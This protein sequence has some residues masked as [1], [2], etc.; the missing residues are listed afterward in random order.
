MVEPRKAHLAGRLEHGLGPEHVGSEEQAGVQDGQGVVRLGGEVDD[1]VDLLAPRAFSAARVADVAL[2]EDDP[3]LDVGQVGS[4]A[5][6]GEHV[7][8]DDMVLGV[9]LDPVSA[10]FDPMKP[11]PP[12]TR[13]RIVP[14]ILAEAPRAPPVP[15]VGAQVHARRRRYEAGPGRR[16]DHERPASSMPR[17]ARELLAGQDRPAPPGPAWHS[18]VGPLRPG[19]RP[20]ASSSSGT[21]GA[22]AANRRSR[23]TGGRPVA[24]S[25]P[26]VVEA[27]SP[28]PA[29][30][31]QATL[32]PIPTT[33]AASERLPANSASARTPASFAR[34]TNR[35]LGHLSTA[36]TPAT[37]RQ[38]SAPAS[39]T[40]ARAQ[41][42]VAR[43][44]S[45]A[46][47]GPRPAGSPPAATPSAGRAG[48]VRRSGGRPPRRVLGG[49][50]VARQ[51][52]DIACWSSRP[53]RASGCPTRRPTWQT[54]YG[55]CNCEGPPQ[56]E[57][58]ACSRRS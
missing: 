29:G 37:S 30:P 45:R 6:I 5:G 3:V 9:L 57:R 27:G 16:L 47:G 28:R 15:S 52:T 33:T 7:V 44:R 11:A 10:K 34:P 42:H 56:E 26:E 19:R 25:P 54:P 43:P 46:A 23:R 2:D 21:S 51:V 39:A 8:D 12:V 48:R 53:R 40:A 55:A 18:G 13:R 14:A 24:P 41:V 36:S 58:P 1:R 22:S 4:V 50:P 38:A 35:S 31:G 49:R 17:P 20:P 32:I